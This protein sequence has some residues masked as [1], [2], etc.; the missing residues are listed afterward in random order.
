MNSSTLKNAI[1]ERFCQPEYA[2]FFEV[3]NR[4]GSASR[5]ADAI[6][7]NLFPSRGLELH[8]F[9]IKVS[10]SDWLN[11][12]KNPAKAEE[13]AKFCERWWIVCTENVVVKEELPPTW[14][15]LVFKDGKLRQIV[16]A[17]KLKAQP[18]TKSF[19]AALLRRANQLDTTQLNVEVEKRVA[20]IKADYESRLQRELDFRTRTQSEILKRAAEIKEACG[21]DLMSY[22]PTDEIGAAINAVITSGVMSNYRGLTTLLSTIKLMQKNLEESLVMFPNKTISH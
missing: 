1:R 2:T 10:R 8:G 20:Q 17:P 4:T 3:A 13:I 5:Y 19:I 16:A 14:G 9:E 6:A 18:L 12:L 21:I 7:M 11:E 22:I 15:L